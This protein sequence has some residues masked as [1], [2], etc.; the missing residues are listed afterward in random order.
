MTTTTSIDITTST[1]TSTTVTSTTTAPMKDNFIPAP[2]RAIDPSK[3]MIALTFDD[4]PTGKNTLTILDLL[5]ASGGRATFFNIGNSVEAN[6]AAAKAIVA[7]GSQIAGHSWTHSD[8]TGLSSAEILS[9]MT[10]TRDV[11]KKVTGIDITMFRPP[12][13]SSNANLLAVAKQVNE[14]AIN[15]SID[16]NDWN[17][18]SV[19][20]IYNNIINNANKNGAIVLCHENQANTPEAMKKVIPELAK[21]YQLVTVEELLYYSTKTISAGTLYNNK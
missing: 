15:W 7:Q 8:L 12:Y 14:A 2:N 5:T 11:I 10:R 9:E 3:P 13:G 18:A 17:G 16:S 6:S 21:T 1:T 20:Q 19:D 4:G